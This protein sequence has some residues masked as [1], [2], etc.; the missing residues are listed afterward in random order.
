MRRLL[1]ANIGEIVR[2]RED[3]IPIEFIVI[4]K[5][6]PFLNNCIFVNGKYIVPRD[7][8]SPKY[9]GFRHGVTLLRKDIHSVGKYDSKNNDYAN[10]EIRKWCNGTYLNTIQED[11]RNQIMTVKIPYRAW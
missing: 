4:Q 5:G 10:S 2:I 8:P 11:I 7:V 9:V 3:N 1:E 6:D